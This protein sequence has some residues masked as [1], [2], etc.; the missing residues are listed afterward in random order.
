MITWRIYYDDGSVFDSSNG[1][2]EDAPSFGVLCIVFPDNDHGRLVMQ[3]WDWL[4]YHEVEGNWWGA[5]IH[6]LLD[7]LLHNKPI[8]AVKQGRNAPALVWREVLN[9]ATN[10]LDFP[11][12]SASSKRERPFQVT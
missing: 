2:P 10:D 12:K 1:E 7:G 3:G 5:D 6:G 8:R 11:I 4:Y 9:R